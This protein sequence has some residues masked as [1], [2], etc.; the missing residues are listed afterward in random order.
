VHPLHLLLDATPL[1]KDLSGVGYVTYQYGKELQRRG[2]RLSYYYAWFYSKELRERPLGGYERA[3]NWAKRYLPRPYLLTHSL[4]T[5][6]FNYTLLRTKP[7]A[8]IQPNYISFESLFDVPTFTFIHDLSHIRYKEFHPKERVDYFEKK[9]EKSIQESRKIIT[10]SNFTK[11]ELVEL[12]LCP[13]EKIEVI[14]N[15]VDPKFRPISQEQ[16]SPLAQRYGVEYRGYFLFVG[17]LEPRKN[18]GNLLRAYLDYLSKS[19]NPKPLLLAGG[20]G[21]RGEYFEELLQRALA[22]GWV[23][24]LGYVQEEELIGLYGGAR[25]FLF[26]SFYEGFGLP[27]LEAMACGTPVIA[28]NSSSIPEVV[29]EGGILIDPHEPETRAL[30]KVDEEAQLRHQLSQRGL[31]QARKFSWSKSAQQ[32]YELIRQNI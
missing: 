8:F 28:S 7:D 5:L 23:R 21:W 27:P 22:T 25:A 14:Y 26:P 15:G 6:I 17:T 32:L 1:L 24:R 29:G 10:I 11:R 2:A 19:S 31:I 13:E 9:L 12:R 18:L 20:G 4:K 16:F 3:I 30:L